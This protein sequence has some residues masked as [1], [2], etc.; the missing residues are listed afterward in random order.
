[1]HNTLV[2]QYFTE[3]IT[4]EIGRDLQN[5]AVSKGS[6]TP[7]NLG[8]RTILTWAIFFKQ[9]PPGIFFFC[10]KRSVLYYETDHL[11]FFSNPI[12]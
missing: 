8:H 2:M 7:D 1:M 10:S 9:F 5:L 11:G 6:R 3:D 4:G 12:N